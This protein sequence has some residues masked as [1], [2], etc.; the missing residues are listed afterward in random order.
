[1]EKDRQFAMLR[2]RMIFEQTEREEMKRMLVSVM[3]EN[4]KLRERFQAVESQPLDAEG[5]F[6]HS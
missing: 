2:D 3:K 1:M 6:F 5:S 4:Q